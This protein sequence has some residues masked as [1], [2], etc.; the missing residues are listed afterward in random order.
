MYIIIGRVWFAWSVLPHQNVAP[1]PQTKISIKKYH[2]Y[3]GENINAN[4]SPTTSMMINFV[5]Y[6]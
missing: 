2:N 6:Q 3:T 4:F 1:F 5:S